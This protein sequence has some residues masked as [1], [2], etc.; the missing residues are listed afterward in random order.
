MS[1]KSL[2]SRTTND[3]NMADLP[4]QAYCGRGVRYKA[5]SCQ[6]SARDMEGAASCSKSGELVNQVNQG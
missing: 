5:I 6:T 4:N 3:T 1:L 2:Q